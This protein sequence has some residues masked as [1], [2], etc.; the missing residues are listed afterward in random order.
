M[1]NFF[2]NFF[3]V[4]YP[5]FKKNPLYIFG[6]SYGGHYV[7]QFAYDLF[8]TDRFDIKDLNLQGVAIGD[9]LT[10]ALI[11]LSTYGSYVF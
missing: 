3:F 8:A 9:G 10:Q 6:E 1:M 4:K 11:Q 5:Q 2:Y 7:P